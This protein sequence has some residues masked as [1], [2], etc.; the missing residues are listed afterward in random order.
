MSEPARAPTAD[1]I[2]GLGEAILKDLPAP[3]RDA[4]AEVADLWSRT[5]RTTRPS[6]PWRSRTRWI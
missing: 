2:A 6:T 5:G 3:F 1:D 4:V